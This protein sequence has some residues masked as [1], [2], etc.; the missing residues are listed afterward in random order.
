MLYRITI[1]PISSFV[2]KLQS[3]TFFGAFCWSYKYL[4]GDEQLEIFLD[5]CLQGKPKVIFSNAFPAG[6]LPVPLGVYQ[7]PCLLD[8]TEDK[9]TRKAAYE[10]NKEYKKFDLN[11]RKLRY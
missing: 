7:R 1:K 11:N 5:E 10:K 6:Y 3:D 8:M 2:S 4:Y 9:K